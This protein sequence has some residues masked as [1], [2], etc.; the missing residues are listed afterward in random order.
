MLLVY[1]NDY[2]KTGILLSSCVSK[3]QI[4]KDRIVS[5]DLVLN[6]D[7]SICQE[8]FWLFEWEKRDD[9]SYARKKQKANLSCKDYKFTSTRNLP[10]IR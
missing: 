10:K 9:T 6:E 3:E 1:I 5:G 4:I 8:D 2:D 7:Y